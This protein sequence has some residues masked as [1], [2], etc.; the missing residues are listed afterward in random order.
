MKVYKEARMKKLLLICLLM[1]SGIIISQ[2]TKINKNEIIP[3][4]IDF[5]GRVK[6]I[7]IKDLRFN[8]KNNKTD[9]VSTISEVYFSKKGTIQLLKFYTKSLN[10]LWKI[11]QFDSLE[12]IKTISINNGNLTSN[13]VNQYFSGDSEFPDSTLINSYEKYKEKYINRFDKKLVVKQEYYVND[14]L[15]DYRLY[16]YN[17]ENQLIEDLY[18]NPENDTDLTLVTSETNNGVKMSFYPERYIFYEYKKQNDTTI[19]IKIRPKY[20]LKEITK[21][22]KNKKVD[23]KIMEKYDKDFLEELQTTWTSKD[24][25]SYILRM[26]NNKREIKNYYSSFKNSKNIVYK[27][28]SDFFNEKEERIEIIDI[29][30]AYD[31]FK[32]WIKKTYSSKGTMQYTVERKIEYY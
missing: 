17:K 25:I 23:L 7:S 18:L 32:N 29:E 30:T 3:T 1:L 31:K 28:K 4:D 8:K 15:Q 16:K 27:S 22:L 9:T 6:K 21:T 19:V 10:D 14:S 12:R 13:Q 20:S 24:S 2:N 11:V 5:N 26:Y